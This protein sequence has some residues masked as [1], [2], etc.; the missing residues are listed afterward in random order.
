MASSKRNSGKGGANPMW[1]GRFSRAPAEIMAEIN[2]SI[3]VDKRLY[4]QD[5]AGSVAHAK[6]LAKQKIISAEDAKTIVGGLQAILKEIEAGKF[7]FKED[8]EDIHMNIEAA[9]QE[10]IGDAAGR[11]HT[12]RS[13][14]DQVA[15]DFRLWVREALDAL[16]ALLKDL[17]KA[18]I[19]RASEHADTL[20]PGFTHLQTAQPVTLGHHL[21]AYVEMFG[22]DRSRLNDARKR[23][24]E[25]PLGAAALAGT[26]FPI[27]RRF[28][29]KELGFDRPMANSLDAV[30]DRDF[31]LEFL[32]LASICAVH[33]SRLA[34]EFV[35]WSSSQ[36]GFIRFSDAFSTGS[37]IMPQKRNPDAAELV[38]GKAGA[39]FGNLIALLTVM[40]ALPLAYNKD[41]QEDKTPVFAAADNL[42][43]CIQAMAGMVRDFAAHKERM[44]KVAEEGYSTATD[45]ADW[46]ACEL[47]MPFRQAHHLTA[48]IV[49]FA[50][51][52][53]KPLTSLTLKELQIAEPKMT[54]AALYV[55]RAADSAKSR[56]SLGG[57]AP[58]NVKKAVIEAK[59][60][61]GL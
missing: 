14:N 19:V 12:A 18:L 47:K 56:V 3:G 11:L 43:L 50:V 23:M 30:S 49:A 31:A 36:F 44:A 20:M 17:Q 10:R 61:F 46:F 8:L 60:R 4:R 51:A 34:E 57:T 48:K 24:N 7:I 33:L 53:K 25:S 58:A 38:R 45:L 26:S 37:S 1:G 29:A 32:S 2:A 28:T 35:L 54:Q 16:D 15:T 9:L 40:K 59:K 42:T 6:M 21:L 27:D 55:L 41:M 13:R 5:I 22:R 52:K 39:I